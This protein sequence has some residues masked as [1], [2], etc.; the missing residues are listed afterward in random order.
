[1]SQD[2]SS[3]TLPTEGVN[4]P[5]PLQSPGSVQHCAFASSTAAKEAST[6]LEDQQMLLPLP[7]RL[8]GQEPVA[9]QAGVCFQEK[10]SSQA[11]LSRPHEQGWIREAAQ[12]QVAKEHLTKEQIRVL[13]QQ[14]SKILMAARAEHAKAQ[15]AAHQAA[16]AVQVAADLLATAEAAAARVSMESGFG[17][18]HYAHSTDKAVGNPAMLLNEEYLRQMWLLEEQNERE[19]RKSA[20]QAGASGQGQVPPVTL[21]DYSQKNALIADIAAGKYT[22]LQLLQIRNQLVMQHHQMMQHYQMMLRYSNFDQ[23]PPVDHQ[24]QWLMLQTHPIN[25]NRQDQQW[26]Q[27]QQVMQQHHMMHQQQMLTKAMDTNL[28]Q[29]KI[30]V[31]GGFA[32]QDHKLPELPDHQAQ[33]QASN[34]AHR[35]EMAAQPSSSE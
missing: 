17:F 34:A 32:T 29:E 22:P 19:K 28:E 6:K 18:A 23:Q 1:M 20:S 14:S 21:M 26:T 35:S 4:S 10:N 16:A 27:H 7:I 13:L 2:C 11:P 33:L 5:S 15:G 25:F 31:N 24:F 3:G 9:P 8:A 12:A 30:G